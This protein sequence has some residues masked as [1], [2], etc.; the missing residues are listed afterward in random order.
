MHLLHQEEDQMT[1]EEKY[2]RDRLLACVTAIESAE[3][4][5]RGERPGS[6]R[7]SPAVRLGL[8]LV[9]KKMTGLARALDVGLPSS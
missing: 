1:F 4:V 3:A 7:L 6:A 5:A 2:V 8:S 9:R